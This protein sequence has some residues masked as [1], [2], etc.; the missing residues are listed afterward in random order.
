MMRRQR[1]LREWLDLR[2]QLTEARLT[3][4]EVRKLGLLLGGGGLLGGGLRIPRVAAQSSSGDG[5]VSPPTTPWLER[6]P[7]P[8][9]ASPVAPFATSAA[10]QFFARFPPQR[11]YRLTL[12]ER[13]HSFH[14]ELPTSPIFGYNG[15]FPG[16]TVDAR[17][18]RPILVRFVNELPPLASARGFGVPQDITHLHNFH[19]ASESDGGPWD[20]IDPGQSRDHHYTLARA[21]FTVPDT[22]PAEFRGS[23]GGDVRESLTTLFFHDHR[24]EFTAAN[25]YKGLAAFC[26]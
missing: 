6:L 5:P 23:D 14:P 15:I 22:I 8:P 24:P 21:G 17:Y 12:Q 3:R 7:I 9:V 2:R 20:W 4:R 16:P 19:S 18:G 10:H 26:R 13:Q 1:E 11:Y 25:V